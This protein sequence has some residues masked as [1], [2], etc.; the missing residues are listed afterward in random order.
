MHERA[1]HPVL[2]EVVA[3]GELQRVHAIERAVRAFGGEALDRRGDGG[4]G[5]L[6]QH[7]EAGLD[8]VGNANGRR[9]AHVR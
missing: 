6:A 9:L 8:F 2:V 3:R 7:G 1:Q 4:V 5:R